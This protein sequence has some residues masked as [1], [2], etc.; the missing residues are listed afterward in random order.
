VIDVSVLAAASSVEATVGDLTRHGVDQALIAARSGLAYRT[1]V[2][3]DLVLSQAGAR[4]GVTLLPVAT[5]NPVEYLDWPTELERV[6][7]AGTV[8]VRFHPEQQ[9]WSVAS[10]A[11]R[12]MARA[13]RGRCPLLVPVTRFGDASAIGEATYQA[14]APVI[15]LGGHYTQLG[16]CLAALQRWPHLYLETSSLGQFRGIATV[17]REVG[18]ERLLFGSATPTR[19]IQAP[20]NAVLTASIS[21]REQR[22]ILADNAARLFG[23]PGDHVVAGPLPGPS[24]AAELVDVH[25]HVGALGLPTPEIED[26][27]TMAA[28]HGIVRS[29]ASSLRA[30]VDD[31]EAGNAEGFAVAN[32]ALLTYV[33]LDPRDV[34]GSCAAMDAAYARDLVVGAKIHCSWSQSPTASRASVDLLREVARRG[35]PL[36]IHVDGPDWPD[37]LADVAHDF[38]DWKLIVAHAG[39]GTPVLETADLIGRTSNVYAELATSFPDRNVIRQVVRRIGPERLLFGS[40]APLIDPAYVHGIYADAQADWTSTAQ[41]AREV[42]GW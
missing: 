16:D 2:A 40:D 32:D 21:E 5:L 20:L 10:E 29:V 27:A 36:L 19:P 8:G 6:L 41:L 15:L 33:V 31:A 4:D 13:I 28:Q 11:F 9:K 42:F 7:A 14:D 37:A 30:I 26:H 34:E 3:N 12:S 22:A 23:L 35:R 39:P 25:A 18:A 17:V 1:R 24:S 38:R